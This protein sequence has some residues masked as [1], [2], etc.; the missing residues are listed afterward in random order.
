MSRNLPGSAISPPTRR[1][2][3]ERKASGTSA[4]IWLNREVVKNITETRCSRSQWASPAGSSVVS[5]GV[6]TSRAPWTSA[7]QTSNVAASNEALEAC[8][9]RS[10]WPISM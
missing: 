2:R 6:I 1:Q 10:S 3:S 7:P 9:M 5:R 4:T 8:A